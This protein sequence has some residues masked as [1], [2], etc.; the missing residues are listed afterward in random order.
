MGIGEY[1]GAL[2]VF[3]GTCDSLNR[4][5][6]VGFLFCCYRNNRIEIGEN[7]YRM[8]KLIVV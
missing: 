7:A 8:N 2:N 5:T 3:P 1:E 6:L 4:P